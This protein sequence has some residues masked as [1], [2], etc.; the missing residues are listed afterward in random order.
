MSTREEVLEILGD[1][2]E[3][4]TD[5]IN[6]AVGFKFSADLDSFALLSF[7]GAVEDHFGIN[8]PSDAFTGMTK[9]DDVISYVDC[10]R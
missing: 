1:Y 10:H 3:T 5:R 8:I 4:P 7:V 6:T 9:L 2:V